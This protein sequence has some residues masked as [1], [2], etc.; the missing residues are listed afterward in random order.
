MDW[1]RHIPPNSSQDLRGVEELQAW[2]EEEL[3]ETAPTEKAPS[4]E[5]M[6]EIPPN[7]SADL[8][9]V[10]EVHRWL[11]RMAEREMAAKQPQ[12]GPAARKV[13]PRPAGQKAASNPAPPRKSASTGQKAAPAFAHPKE[14]S[15][16]VGQKQEPESNEEEDKRRKKRMRESFK[17][18]R[19]KEAGLPHE[20]RASAALKKIVATARRDIE[21]GK[22]I[23]F[24]GTPHDAGRQEEGMTDEEQC[25]ADLYSSMTIAFDN[26]GQPLLSIE[27]Q[28]NARILLQEQ[29]R[30]WELERQGRLDKKGLP[31]EGRTARAAC[32]RLVSQLARLIEPTQVSQL[33]WESELEARE[34]AAMRIIE[35]IFY[36]G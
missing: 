32:R 4:D 34:R 36:E 2:E 26:V 25:Y 28:R 23:S 21:R 18:R 35:D 10:E 1:G 24:G 17:S 20:D 33:V 14:V 15:G 13:A 11:N 29:E 19:N 7:T 30:L 27:A 16:S 22:A 5:V 31:E 12:S 9:R 6:R 8:R 3:L